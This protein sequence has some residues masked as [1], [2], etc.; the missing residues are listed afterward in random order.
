MGIDIRDGQQMACITCALCI[1]ACDDVMTR[2]GKP[3]GLIDYL[4]LSDE[5]REREGN[6]P[7]PVWHHVFRTRTLLYTAIWSVF[8]A[9]LVYG[10]FVRAEIDM[11]VAPV[12]NPQFVT[13]SDGAIRN[14]YDLRLRNK[15]GEDR[16]F[17]IHV[18]GDLAL[19]I[20][21][22]GTVY[23][24]TMVPADTSA[25]QRVY[26]IAPPR[27]GPATRERTEIRFWVED[28]TSGERASRASIF[29]GKET[30]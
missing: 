1:D 14:T 30:P 29:N 11:T 13:L 2:I 8:G 7:R 4:A 6:T 10:L 20:T 18:N 28:L 25:L 19:R 17:R 9:L 21:L 5:G 22:E 16:P 15:H 12:R 23:D 24:Q 3:R 27:S 26:V